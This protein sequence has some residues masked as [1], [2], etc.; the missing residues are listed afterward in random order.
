MLLKLLQSL[1]CVLKFILLPLGVYGHWQ[2][3]EKITF[4]HEFF[5]KPDPSG[6]FRKN[7]HDVIFF[8]C[9]TE[10]EV[11]LLPSFQFLMNPLIIHL[12]SVCFLGGKGKGF[13]IERK[14]DVR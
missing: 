10:L 2:R 8:K 13:K 7:N 1:L 11:I 3:K 5:R 14:E 12:F 6:Y 4:L 9:K